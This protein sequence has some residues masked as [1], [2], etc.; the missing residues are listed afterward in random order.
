MSDVPS[1][2]PSRPPWR[3]GPLLLVAIAAAAAAFWRFDVDAGGLPPRLSTAGDAAGQTVEMT[4]DCGDGEPRRF[5]TLPWR[6]GMT[7]ENALNQAKRRGLEVERQ[8]QEAGAFI[9]ALAGVKNQG[10]GAEAKNW[11]LFVNGQ[12]ARQSYAVT[13]LRPGDRVLWKFAKYE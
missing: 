2:Q 10:A 7:V 5:G 4:V 13:P 6:R 12:A 11:I 9:S 1:N 3:A 8:G